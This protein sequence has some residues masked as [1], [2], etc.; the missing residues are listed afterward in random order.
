[1]HKKLPRL[2]GTKK[3]N[4]KR[5][6]RIK[7]EC[8]ASKEEGTNREDADTVG[9]GEKKK[10]LPIFQKINEMVHATTPGKRKACRDRETVGRKNTGTFYLPKENGGC[11]AREGD[12]S[13]NTVIIIMRGG[14]L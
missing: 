12:Q 7:I 8:S 6:T 4:E 10:T 14:A 1:V 5:T 11:G 13:A 3:L 2:R 9:G